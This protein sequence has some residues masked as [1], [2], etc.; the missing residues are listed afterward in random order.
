MSTVRLTP[1]TC[2]AVSDLLCELLGLAYA[3]DTV[4][5]AAFTTGSEAVEILAEWAE[6][7]LQRN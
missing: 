6:W 4:P 2:Q 7:A 1:G 3:E 5:L